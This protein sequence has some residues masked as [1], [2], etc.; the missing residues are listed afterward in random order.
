L[1]FDKLITCFGAP[2]EKMVSAIGD[3]A[4]V[5]KQ[6]MDLQQAK[7]T[8][9]GYWKGE[10]TLKELFSQHGNK[11]CMMAPERMDCLPTLVAKLQRDLF[12]LH[13]ATI[14]DKT[15]TTTSRDW[16]FGL[17]INVHKFPVSSD[18]RTEDIALG[19]NFV[20]NEWL[21]MPLWPFIDNIVFLKQLKDLQLSAGWATN[22]PVKVTRYLGVIIM[23]GENT[24]AIQMV[25]DAH[26]GVWLSNNDN[27]HKIKWGTLR[28]DLHHL[29]SHKMREKT[30]YKPLIK[31]WR[32]LHVPF[33]S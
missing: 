19:L 31:V 15:G 8:W 32:Y 3:Q 29:Q 7:L 2:V 27:P 18:G 5:C 17:L 9:E 16:K 11:L 6:R 30:F 23:S 28:M 1:D 13:T 4:V 20:K 10:T 26:D 12:E 22:T 25:K 24:T 14:F 21:E 33:P